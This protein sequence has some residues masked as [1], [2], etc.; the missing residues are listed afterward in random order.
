[1]AKRVITQKMTGTVRTLYGDWKFDFEVNL[2][3]RTPTTCY[4]KIKK[5]FIR[6]RGL[7]AWNFE[8]YDV[9]FE[10]KHEN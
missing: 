10:V 4:N 1:M 8:V 2:N 9:H 3:Q 6:A 5:A 7:G